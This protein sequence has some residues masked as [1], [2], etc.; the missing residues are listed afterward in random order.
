MH[1]QIYVGNVHVPGPVLGSGDTTVRET[2]E[3]PDLMEFTFY[4]W[5]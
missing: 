3:V 5:R 2:A 4:Q 1:S